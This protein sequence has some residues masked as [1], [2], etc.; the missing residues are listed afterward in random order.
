MKYLR[1]TIPLIRRVFFILSRNNLFLEIFHI[2]CPRLFFNIVWGF[3]RLSAGPRSVEGGSVERKV[4]QLWVFLGMKK[5]FKL[6][7]CL[8]EAVKNIPCPKPNIFVTNVIAQNAI[9]QI[10]VHG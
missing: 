9:R 4:V 2:R 7:T 5:C 10:V 1:H 3:L 8:E 6:S